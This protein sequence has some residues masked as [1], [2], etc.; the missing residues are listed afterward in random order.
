MAVSVAR[1]VSKWFGAVRVGQCAG[2]SS[3][4]CLD[5]E[6]GGRVHGDL[7]SDGFWSAVQLF[8]LHLKD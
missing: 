6:V 4:D 7:L 2:D 1:G 3:A 8:S 5:Y